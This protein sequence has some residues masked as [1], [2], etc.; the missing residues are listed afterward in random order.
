MKLSEK[1][2]ILHS[3][4]SEM[5]DFYDNG[6]LLI[7]KPLDRILR[8]VCLEESREPDKVYVWAFIQPLYIPQ[9]TEVFNFGKRLGGG[10]ASWGTTE[11]GVISRL[12]SEE[13]LPYLNTISGPEDFIKWKQ[14]DILYT[15]QVIAYSLVVIGNYSDGLFALR[16]LMDLIPKDL[17]YDY[18]LLLKEQVAHLTHLCETN[19]EKAQALL[20]QWELFT[21]SSLRLPLK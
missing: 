4:T 1:K 10:C 6:T 3:I 19:P 9:T 14:S 11:S 21:R 18:L 7:Y 12:V 17:D 16:R 5:N 2:K 15:Q 8:G 13:G 20:K